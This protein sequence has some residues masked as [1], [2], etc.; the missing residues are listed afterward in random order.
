MA[1]K[2]VRRRRHVCGRGG[3]GRPSAAARTGTVHAHGLSSTMLSRAPLGWLVACTSAD[4]CCCSGLRAFC[5]AEGGSP[6]SGRCGD[7]MLDTDSS[8]AEPTDCSVPSTPSVLD[9]LSLGRRP[10]EARSMMSLVFRVRTDRVSPVRKGRST[11]HV[12]QYCRLHTTTF[13]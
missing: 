2:S 5:S 7:P 6:G 10:S 4:C 3:P 1:A 11:T 13:L 8:S 12:R 9:T